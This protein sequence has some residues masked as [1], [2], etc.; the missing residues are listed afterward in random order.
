MQIVWRS[1][2]GFKYDGHLMDRK[3]AFAVIASKLGVYLSLTS[4]MNHEES[5]S[6]QYSEFIEEKKEEVRT[7]SYKDDELCS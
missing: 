2:D 3:L 1:I 7:I 6:G 4:V 5:D